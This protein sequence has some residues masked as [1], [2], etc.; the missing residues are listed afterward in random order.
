MKIAR[1]WSVSL[2]L[3]LG[4][5]VS[6]MARSAP[7]TVSVSGY[8]IDSSC[9]FT[10]GLTK[11]VSPACAVACARAGSPLVILSDQGTIYWPI[12]ITTPAKGQN[13]RL[14]PFAGRRV[15]VNGKI[16]DKG[17]SHAIV[18]ERIEAAR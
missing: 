9:A 6:T 13:F 4:V 2:L 11:P 1:A 18:I 8:V 12:S 15:A 7:K 3:V 16:Y 10:K 17:G 5:A 14:M